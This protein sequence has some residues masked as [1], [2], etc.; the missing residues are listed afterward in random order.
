MPP[1]ITVLDLEPSAAI[2]HPT[3]SFEEALMFG[4]PL[5]KPPQSLS[6]LPLVAS[7]ALPPITLCEIAKILFSA[8]GVVAQ[9]TWRGAARF[10]LASAPPGIAVP[11]PPPPLPRPS[12]FRPT[13]PFFAS[14]IVNPL[15]PY[16]PTLSPPSSPCLPPPTAL[17]LPGASAGH[18]TE[19]HCSSSPTHPVWVYDLYERYG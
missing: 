14:T 9:A 15:I 17:P 2:T 5:Q 4:L 19:I 6:T 16:R 7:S 12:A 11:P 18:T 13:H 3:M 10:R 1:D 8:I